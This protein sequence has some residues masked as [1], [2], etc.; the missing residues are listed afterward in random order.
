MMRLSYG[1]L[2]KDCDSKGFILSN[3]AGG[4]SCFGIESRYRGAFFNVAGRLL[5]VID[6][7]QLD[8]PIDSVHNNLTGVQRKRGSVSES[9]SM[10]L[11]KNCLV[12]E[13]SEEKKVSLILDV[14]SPYDNLE[15]GRHYSFVDAKDALVISYTKS[16]D[17]RDPD[18]GDEFTV[19]V[20]V[21][22]DRSCSPVGAWR[23]QEYCFDRLRDSY[24]HER[25]V[26]HAADIY[27]KRI[28][29]SVAD[30]A[31]RAISQARR[32]AG[33]CG[34]AQPEAVSGETGLAY[35]CSV[36]SLDSL[37]LLKPR[38]LAGLPWFFQ[39]WLRDEAICLKALLLQGNI[40][41]VK[42]ILTSQ[43]CELENRVL[44]ADAVGWHFKRWEDL[45]NHLVAKN[46]LRRYLPRRELIKLAFQLKNIL[47]SSGSLVVNQ[48]KAT[49]MD[50]I[51]RSGARIE[52]QALQLACHRLMH[53]LSGD[54]L[55]K[56]KELELKSLVRQ[57]FFRDGYLWDSPN[58]PTV[59]PNIFIAA[60]VYPELLE[61]C[62]WIRC[63]D[64]IL[65]KLW[66][67][68]GGLST[69]DTSS[70]LFSS[71]HTGENPKSYHN[72]DSWFWI[73]NL[74]CQVLHALDKDRFSDYIKSVFRASTNEI[75]WSGVS[76]H[77]AELSSAHAF[78]SEGCLSQAW[79]S[80]MYIEMVHSLGGGKP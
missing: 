22:S 53:T 2:E 43:L 17:S 27:A 30:S 46:I 23:L 24:P 33:S 76:G 20:A 37:T 63:F 79:S 42:K 71:I 80:A 55:E 49:W 35:Q 58:D 57:E 67:G 7:I 39:V 6:D 75:L 68:W 16:F 1:L 12:Y 40:L 13:L 66:L 32:L 5:K 59:R 72:G 44:Q 62:E 56:R 74:A 4:F 70:S 25:Y 11:G 69:V 60:Y 18:P 54:P 15:W 3:K 10:P 34:A 8:L 31:A 38:I 29:F 14:R 64:I 51:D 65:P 50:S 77:H 73:N 45:I 52:L 48:P 28:V 36:T 19:F 26:Y 78:K 61:S 21:L 47:D 41:A 9:F